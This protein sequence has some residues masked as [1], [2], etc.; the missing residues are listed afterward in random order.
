VTKTAIWWTRRDLR[1]T[2]NQALSAALAHAEQVIPVF[3]L[4]PT[5]LADNEAARSSTEE[6][7]MAFLFGGLQ[8]LDE[9]LRARGGTLV[10]RQGDPR[11]ELAALLI[12]T[13]AEAIYAEA[14]VWPY[15][16]RRDSHIAKTLPLHLTDGLTIHPPDAV[17]KA[18]G[19][20]YVVFT[21]YSRKWKALPPPTLRDI[22]PAPERIAAP[23]DVASLPVPTEPALPSEVP[24]PPGEAEAQRRLDAFLTSD[25]P[26]V[27]SYAETRDRMDL[28][29]T[30][31]LSPY[32]RFGMLSARQ[33]AAMAGLARELAPGE[34]AGQGVEAWLDELIWREF[35]QA[36]LHH[37]PHV[38]ERS[39]RPDLQAIPWDNDPAA[40]YVWCEGHTGYPVVDAAMRQLAHT[41]WMP[42]RARMIVASF[43]VKD[44]LTDWR[45]GERFFMQ[46]LVDGD[47]AANNGGWQWTAG[48]GTD[49]APYFRVFNPVTQGKKCDPQGAY[50]RRWVTVLANVPD[51]FIHEPWKMPL[52]VQ[53]STGCVIGQDYPAPIVD[54]AWARE[55]TLAAYAKAKEETLD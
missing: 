8:A 25:D 19:T 21:P 41:G 10:V 32:L 27:Y 1:L 36:I 17:L 53:Q 45:W 29:G 44:L 30:S 35:Y 49:A 42:N 38:L 16:A 24:F 2:D 15:G 39:F 28:D 9:S 47:P 6:K 5:L 31:R 3:V 54:H 37:F 26:P 22:L 48:T 14:D 7:R 50:V 11:D 43:L 34:E 51:R 46:H 20:P 23:P 52:D 18:D 40:F 13:G 4:D 33:A 55:R 12:E